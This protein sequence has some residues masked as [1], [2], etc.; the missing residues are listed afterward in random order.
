MDLKPDIDNLS[1]KIAAEYDGEIPK[2][3]K[4]DLITSLLLTRTA[5]IKNNIPVYYIRDVTC[6]KHKY[7]TNKK[8]KK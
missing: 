2:P 5:S 1:N 8:N 6:F 4:K 3:L 7:I